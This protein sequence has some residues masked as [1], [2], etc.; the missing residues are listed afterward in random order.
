LLFPGQ[1]GPWLSYFRFPTIAGMM[2]GVHHCAQLL[3]EMGSC[4]LFALAGLKLIL[5][6]S[7]SQVGRITGVG[8]EAQQKTHLDGL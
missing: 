4:Q 8:H 5:P 1:C 7:A 2:T 3:V 6:T